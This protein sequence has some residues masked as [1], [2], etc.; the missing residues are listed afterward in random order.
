MYPL[1]LDVSTRLIVIV[2]AGPVGMRKAQGVIDAGATR[3]RVVSLEFP[4]NV[5][6]MIEKIVARFEPKHL[7]DAGLVFACTDQPQV[8]DAVVEEARRIGVLVNRA[9]VDDELASD[10]SSPAVHR[11]GSIVIAAATSGVPGL[12][13]Q[14][15]DELAGHI[16]P[17]WV[18][19]SNAMAIL[20]PIIK[21]QPQLSPALRKEIFKALASVDA[22]HTIEQSDLGGLWS[23]LRAKFP[24]LNEL[25]ESQ[26][27]SI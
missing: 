19:L 18:K 5:S 22:I 25:T 24:E 3:I 7:Q 4:S 11:V 10:F 12:A 14:I 26:K 23:W 9:D 13:T 2:G 6:P 1:M 16:H 20:R 15:R 17:G 8:N 21:G 27:R